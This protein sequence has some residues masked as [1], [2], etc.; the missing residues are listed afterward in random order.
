MYYNIF[1]RK[2]NPTK[3]Y[4]TLKKACDVIGFDV[5]LPSRFK[6]KEIRVI[7]NKILEIVFS[8]VIVRKTKYSK[9]NL[10]P[11][12]IAKKFPGSYLNDCNKGD[13]VA[14]GIKGIEYWNGSSNRPKTYLAI[15]DDDEHKFSYS[16]FAPKGIMLKSMSI[17]QKYFK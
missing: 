5:E 4:K 17:W 13:F 7:S 2:P 16:V 3:K 8:S 10:E 1:V 15:W 11:S 9:D 12:S 14:S 6:I